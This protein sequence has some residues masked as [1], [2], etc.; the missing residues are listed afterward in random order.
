M[1]KLKRLCILAVVVI[2]STS[3]LSLWAIRQSK[4]VPDFYIQATSGQSLDHDRFAERQ[5]RAGVAQLQ[6]DA[7]RNGSW[8][9]NFSDRQINAWLE[10]ELPTKFPRLLAHGAS[11][12]RVVIRDG[13]LLAAARFQKGHIDTVVSCEVDVQ[14]TE[15]PNILALHVKNLRA[16]AL[17]IPLERFLGG[18]SREAAMGNL[19]VQ[20]DR[21]DQ[22]PVALVR[23]PAEHP[24]YATSPVIVEWIDFA[25]G[26]LELSGHSGPMAESK[27]RP[28]G[29]LHEFV[30]Y[31]PNAKTRTDTPNRW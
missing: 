23:V 11:E 12:P 28:H 27:Y 1:S 21:T 25:A 2:A 10:S 3:V 31:Q 14:L 19:S 22:G 8:K 7:A 16:G 24:N 30:S 26:V 18:V 29:T 9:A 20:W 15:Q 13:K 17:P 4:H 6:N 5:M